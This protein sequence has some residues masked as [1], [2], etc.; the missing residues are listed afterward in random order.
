MPV[1]RRA[2]SV[3]RP[4]IYYGWW[5]VLAYLL[6]NVY[7]SGTLA[8]GLTVFFAP[9]RTSFG[10]SAALLAA[11]FSI[12]N[13][14]ASLLAPVVGVVFD[15]RGPRGLML[16]ASALA[17]IGLVL[18]SR[19]GSLPD[20]TAAFT[21]LSLGFAIWS[22]GTGPAI[23]AL[24][25]ARRRGLA[26]GII[27]SGSSL[28]GVMV[29]LWSAVVSDAGWRTAVL[30]AGAGLLALSLPLCVLLRH[31]PE[32]Y[33]LAPDG[34]APQLDR[35]GQHTRAT[36]ASFAGAVRAW[37]FWALAATATAAAMGV[38]A[39]SV[40][41][42]PSLRDAHVAEA[43]AVAAV[44]AISLLGI[45]GRLGAGWLGDR[46]GAEL[47]LLMTFGLEGAGLVLLA[48]VGGHAAA[49]GPAVLLFGVGSAA[50]FLVPALV[51]VRWF[52][53][54]AFGRIQGL[55]LLLTGLGRAA[56]PTIAGA[57]R[58]A[59]HGYAPAYLLFAA[60]AFLACLPVLLLRG[61]DASPEGRLRAPRAR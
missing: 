28:G 54:R 23:A 35:L 41:I 42:L 24:W 21:L 52:G 46:M 49:L 19:A 15:R 40:H 8:V 31:R 44:T 58:D 59:G 55:L 16:A 48:T 2:I 53:T 7:W 43:T 10:W 6:L 12:E 51:L 4:R 37:Q 36:G 39:T 33:G 13:L 11:I 32:Q 22:A 27:V 17:G 25:F 47:L 56:G 50:V 1:A 60:L 34:A 61:R 18:L 26:M 57:I 45:P 29:P 30:L 14:A 5:I 38:A 20:F 9:I 3:R